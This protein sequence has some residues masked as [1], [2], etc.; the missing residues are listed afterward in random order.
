MAF[1]KRII[2]NYFTHFLPAQLRNAAAKAKICGLL[3]D[4][5]T[6]GVVKFL[7]IALLAW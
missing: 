1:P 7:A 3:E 4:G 5:D 2:P 6:H